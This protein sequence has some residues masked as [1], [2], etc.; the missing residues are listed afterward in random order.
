MFIYICDH[1]LDDMIESL[2]KQINQY[3]T[4]DGVLILPDFIAVG[5]SGEEIVKKLSNKLSKKERDNLKIYNFETGEKGKS[6]QELLIEVENRSVLICDGIVDTG[7]T[8]ENTRK[9]IISRKP[10]DVKTLSVI[11][12]N[13]SKQIPNFYAMAIDRHDEIF[14]NR[15]F[16]PIKFY[17][18]GNIRAIDQSDSGKELQLD[19]APYISRCLD[20][21][22]YYTYID[23]NSKCYVIE[24]DTKNDPVGII[25]FKKTSPHEI[26][27]DAIAVATNMRGNGFA[28][29]MLEFLDN[30]NK[31]NKIHKCKMLAVEEKVPLYEKFEYKKTGKVLKLSKVTLFEMETLV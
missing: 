19:D 26:F 17:P 3:Y 6:I 11:L 28:R 22:I 5:D 12:R 18:K 30:Y 23:S 31:F 13:D 24:E 25:F 16:Y 15:K 8:L 9:Y 20:D 27:V 29:S 4:H 7:K 1:V 10:K 14:F 21:Y 2:A